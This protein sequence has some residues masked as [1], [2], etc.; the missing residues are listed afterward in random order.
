[1]EDE[2]QKKQP[3]INMSYSK[4]P[5]ETQ[6]R[7]DLHK[8]ALKLAAKGIPVF[9]CLPMGKEPA[10]PQGFKDASSDPAQIDVWWF[11][12]PN[13]NL[14]IQPQNMGCAVIDPDGETGLN[15]WAALELEYGNAPDT[16]TVRTPGGGLHLYF[17]GDLPPS[18][19]A[20]ADHIDTRGGGSYALVTCQSWC[21]A[22]PAGTPTSLTYRTTALGHP[23]RS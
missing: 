3:V 8:A 11:E 15:S 5:P 14:A 10:T 7:S 22:C 1:M 9:P 6:S 23:V 16:Y 12:N 19:S 20:L 4:N 21:G 13:Y 2:G 18:Q 17:K